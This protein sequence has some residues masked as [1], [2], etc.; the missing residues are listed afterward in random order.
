MFIILIGAMS[1]MPAVKV[2]SLYAAVAVFIDFL[3]QITWFVAL[4]YLDAKRQESN[5]WDIVCCVKERNTTAIYEEG[6]LYQFMEKFYAPA[7]LSDYVRPCVIAFFVGML[8]TSISMSA[9]LDVGLDQELALPKVCLVYFN[10]SFV[11]ICH[12]CNGVL[13]NALSIQGSWSSLNSLK[14]P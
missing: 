6:F 3:F 1:S 4:M 5:R 14:T 11:I 10:D 12:I 8:F 7:L 2:F 9:K 13:F